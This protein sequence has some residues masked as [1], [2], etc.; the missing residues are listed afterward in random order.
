MYIQ[1]E[2]HGNRK[3]ANSKLRRETWS[4]SFPHS[5]W[6]APTLPTPS[7]QTSNL[8]SSEMIPFC[9]LSTQWAVLCYG[10]SSILIHSTRLLF[11]SSW[12]EVCPWPPL[13]SREAGQVCTRLNILHLKHQESGGKFSKEVEHWVDKPEHFS[14]GRVFSWQVMLGWVVLPPPQLRD[15]REYFGDLIKQWQEQKGSAYWQ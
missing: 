11:T 3:A 5:P 9:C 2:H 7:F 15:L 14:Q 12:P 4:R 8:Q 13:T 1:E 10:S 6:K